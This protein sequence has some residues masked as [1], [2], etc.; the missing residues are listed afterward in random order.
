MR[1]YSAGH[2][3]KPIIMH[4]HTLAESDVA[5]VQGVRVVDREVGRDRTAEKGTCEE[6]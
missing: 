1:V 5:L 6:K 3:N 2:D 4:E